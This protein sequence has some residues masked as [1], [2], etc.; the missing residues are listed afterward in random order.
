MN[1][2]EK[3]STFKL[4]SVG[5]I[6]KSNYVNSCELNAMMSVLDRREKCM[7]NILK[8]SQSAIC[9][10]RQVFKI[11][12]IIFYFFVANRSFAKPWVYRHLVHLFSKMWASV[13]VRVCAN[14]VHFCFITIRAFIISQVFFLVHVTDCTLLN[15]W[16][17]AYK[18][19]STCA[20]SFT[21]LCGVVGKY[22]MYMYTMLDNSKDSIPT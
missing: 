15:Q 4:N 2:N 1:W 16:Y 6:Y 14:G 19:L 10:N 9:R 5:K 11:Q 20:A 21:A 7:L 18:F 13:C 17:Y 8:D 12:R 3:I 22:I